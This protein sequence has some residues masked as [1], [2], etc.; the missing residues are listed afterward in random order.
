M[1]EW[2]IAAVL[3]F[4]GTPYDWNGFVHYYIPDFILIEKNIYVEIKGYKTNKDDA[5]WKSFP[6][7]LKI[8]YGNDLKKMGLKIKL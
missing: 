5:K 3:I 1:A 7:V 2:S 6:H 4:K 8:L